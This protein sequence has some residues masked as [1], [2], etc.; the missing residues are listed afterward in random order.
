MT[1]YSNNLFPILYNEEEE[2]EIGRKRFVEALPYLKQS[3]S[4][5]LDGLQNLTITSNNIVLY[6]EMINTIVPNMN[7]HMPMKERIMFT[8]TMKSNFYPW[9]CTEDG[10][11]CNGFT[12][13]AS[14]VS[15]CVEIILVCKARKALHKLDFEKIE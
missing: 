12:I 10:E 9:Q 11:Y 6:T 14:T 1:S 7:I 4:S 3:L 8:D 2:D 13:A 15:D 5:N